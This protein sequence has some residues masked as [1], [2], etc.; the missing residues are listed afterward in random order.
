MVGVVLVVGIGIWDEMGSMS[1]LGHV[2][3]GMGHTRSILLLILI[4]FSQEIKY[5]DTFSS[6]ETESEEGKM[7]NVENKGFKSIL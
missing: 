1:C 7:R 2:E 5:A 3:G 4:S 6:R